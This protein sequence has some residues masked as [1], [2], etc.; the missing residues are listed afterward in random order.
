MVAL[1]TLTEKQKGKLTHLLNSLNLGTADAN[2]G[3]VF[4]A[5]LDGNAPTLTQ[6]ELDRLA[7]LLNNLNLET[8]HQK[9]GNLFVSLLSANATAV[10]KAL[11]LHDIY[12]I[13]H[14]LNRLN[15]GLTHAGF[16]YV[17]VK[18]LNAVANAEPVVPTPTKTIA[19]KTGVTAAAGGTVAFADMFD[20]GTGS[21]VATD[22]NYVVTPAAGSHGGAV[23][24]ATG[25]LTLDADATGTVT[26]KATAKSGQTITGSPATCSITVS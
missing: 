5:W 7:H 8:H 26:V 25:E 2:V 20:V 9:F 12:Q 16:G 4:V 17:F 19:A 11:T 15:L 18:A 1:V 24:P 13:E 14:M 23:D 21:A 3:D 10:A 22:F 6:R